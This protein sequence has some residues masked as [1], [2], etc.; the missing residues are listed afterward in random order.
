MISM[1]FVITD[2]EFSTLHFGFHTYIRPSPSPTAAEPPRHIYQ[3][4]DV[5][6]TAMLW[7]VSGCAPQHR[8]PRPR[9]LAPPSPSTT[10]CLASA[11]QKQLLGAHPGPARVLF[12]GRQRA[13]RA[14]G[15]LLPA[16]NE[17]AI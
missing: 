13:P 7:P 4:H 11:P 12:R 17:I 9:G 6:L 1:K 5:R 2:D 14:L 3:V 10:R 15:R 8:L 16:P